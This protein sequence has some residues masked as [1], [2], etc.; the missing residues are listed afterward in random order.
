MRA[1][2]IGKRMVGKRIMARVAGKDIR[3]E[4]LA[5]A[6]GNV[7]YRYGGMQY[8]RPVTDVEVLEVRS[9]A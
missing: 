1:K 3:I 2:R 6:D 7:R 5:C 9:A 4:V 8:W